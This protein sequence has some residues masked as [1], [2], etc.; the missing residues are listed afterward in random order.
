MLYLRE[1]LPLELYIPSTLNI[2]LKLWQTQLIM[3][4]ENV[5]SLSKS[6]VFTFDFQ[7]YTL[8]HI[9]NSMYVC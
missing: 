1:L 9:L 5:K 7:A 2:D 6:W 8:P 3:C 4:A